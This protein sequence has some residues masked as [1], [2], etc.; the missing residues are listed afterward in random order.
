MRLEELGWSPHFEAA[1]APYRPQGLVPARV[2][3]QHRGGFELL[4]EDGEPAGVPAGALAELP[5][6]GDW[7]AAAAVPGEDKAVIEAV[8]PRR[9]AFTRTDPWSDAEEVVAANVDT[10]FVVT[11]VGRDFS[12][13]RLERYLA[14]AHESGAGPVVLVNKADLDA[15]DAAGALAEARAAA[16]GVPVHLVSAKRG[17]GLEQLDPYL[18]SGRTVALLGS[19]GVGKSTLANR[20]AGADLLATAEVRPDELGRHTTTRRQLVRLPRGGLLLD[21]PGLRELQLA[22]ADL[23]ETFPEIAALAPRCRF[24]DCSHTH[25][26]GCAVREAVAAGEIPRERY[27]SYLKLAA[28]LAA[29]DERQRRAG[30]R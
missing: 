4:T 8:L 3:T 14:A 10:V 21:T 11:A 30:W 19:S 20:L 25:E 23:R 6:V 15:D 2:A 17:D 1:F 9:T 26:P 12:A 27:D 13:R 18:A 28:E 7:V 22:G 16:P 24:R 29:L 5:A